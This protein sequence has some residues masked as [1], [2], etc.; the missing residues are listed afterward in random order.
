MLPR[1]YKNGVKD[2]ELK[3][4]HRYRIKDNYVIFDIKVRETVVEILF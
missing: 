4:M 3:K 1:L 2:D